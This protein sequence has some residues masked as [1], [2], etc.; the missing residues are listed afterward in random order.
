MTHSLAL[1]NSK[2]SSIE[3]VTTSDVMILLSIDF[4]LSFLICTV[5]TVS[6]F[7]R[8]SPLRI[9]LL[10]ISSLFAAPCQVLL[11]DSSMADSQ[12]HGDVHFTPVAVSLNRFFPAQTFELNLSNGWYCCPKPVIVLYISCLLSFS[13]F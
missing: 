8:K 9:C 11:E 10:W 7:F 5:D 4:F 6:L 2:P 12:A 13:R 3:A 1:Q